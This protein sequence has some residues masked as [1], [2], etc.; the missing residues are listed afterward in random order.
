RAGNLTTSVLSGR[1][2][3]NT[4][5]SVSMSNP[6]ANIRGIVALIADAND[7]GSGVG[8][9]VFQYS[10]AGQN[11]WTTISALWDT[12]TLADGIYDLR[13]IATDNAGNSRASAP[14]SGVR[15]DNT[16]PDATIT[17]PDDNVRGTVSLGSTTSDTG[18]GVST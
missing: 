10:N 9:I 1:R 6:G 17:R 2:V 13:A 18:S 7:S 12:T 5:P 8:N 16:A 3:D 4:A 14:V 11:Q 15:I